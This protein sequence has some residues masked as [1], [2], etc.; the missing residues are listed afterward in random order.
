MYLFIYVGTV[1]YGPAL[2]K[3]CTQKRDSFS[4]RCKNIGVRLLALVGV[5]LLHIDPTAFGP[6]LSCLG[7]ITEPLKLFLLVFLVPRSRFFAYMGRY[8]LGT[9]LTHLAWKEIWC[10]TGLQWHT[11]YN[12]EPKTVTYLP[13]V[14]ASAAWLI[15]KL[16]KWGPLDGLVGFLVLTVYSILFCCVVGPAFQ[17]FLVQT[18]QAIVGTVQFTGSLMCQ[19]RRNDAKQSEKIGLPE[20]N[21]E[22]NGSMESNVEQ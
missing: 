15:S 5:L 11:V 7:L 9:F 3:Y 8:L 10:F 6:Y 12:G 16:P 21:V 2:L 14:G 4:S 13:S 20:S 22:P 18:I 17:I 1:Y 19:K